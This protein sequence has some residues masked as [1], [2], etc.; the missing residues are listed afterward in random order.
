MSNDNVAA[1]WGRTVYFGIL[2]WLPGGVRLGLGFQS[3]IIYHT[4]SHNP[5]HCYH[6]PFTGFWKY[7]L[8]R[9]WKT[10]FFELLAFSFYR[11][12]PRYPSLG[13]FL[14]LSYLISQYS[15]HIHV[16][17]A[18]FTICPRSSL[19]STFITSS[20]H[21]YCSPREPCVTSLA[22]L[23]HSLT[24]SKFFIDIQSSGWMPIPP[25]QVALSLFW[26]RGAGSPSNSNTVLCGSRPASLPSGILIHPAISPQQYNI[27]GPKMGV[28]C[29]APC[30]EGELGLHLTQCCQGQVSS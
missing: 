11:Y 20:L 8:C 6:H 17:C 15:S 27:Y 9:F 1:H 19:F 2:V 25:Y 24:S 22:I 13:S 16:H 18:V 29:C 7:T 12:F 14:S 5:I 26:G 10:A 23:R 30:G 28:E 3:L 4:P 21:I